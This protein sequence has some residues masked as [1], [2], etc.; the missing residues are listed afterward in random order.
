MVREYRGS[1]HIVTQVQVKPGQREASS[2]DD[3]RER[4]FRWYSPLFCCQE[5]AETHRKR[6]GKESLQF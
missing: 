4:T 1:K 6:F 2:K 3:H 5:I